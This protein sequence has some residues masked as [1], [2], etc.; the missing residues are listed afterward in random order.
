ME[1]YSDKSSTPKWNAQRNL[2]GRTHYVDDASLR[3][4][5]SRILRTV[6]AD[7]GLLF[8]LVESVGLDMHNTKRGFRAIVFDVFGTVLHCPGLEHCTKVRASADKDLWAALNEIDAIKHTHDAITANLKRELQEADRAH[9]EL[10]EMT[11]GEAA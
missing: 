4:H 10:D 9:R 7:N 6:V 8:G 11:E 3:F 2:E 5:K 1:L